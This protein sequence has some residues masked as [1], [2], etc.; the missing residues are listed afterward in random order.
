[1]EEQKQRQDVLEAQKA[2]AKVEEQ[3][4]LEAEAARKAEEEK[5]Q[6]ALEAQKGQA[7][8]EEQKRLEAEAARKA[9][10]EKE[11]QALLALQALQRPSKASG[12]DVVETAQRGDSGN[13]PIKAEK[14]TVEEEREAQKG[15]TQVCASSNWLARY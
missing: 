4:R 9:E 14:L 3:K 6:A 7:K 15:G 8:G 2:Q 11:R 10:E 5:R 13:H 12:Q 1:M